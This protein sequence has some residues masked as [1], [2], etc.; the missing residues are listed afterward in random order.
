MVS[1]DSLLHCSREL[2]PI[3]C[4]TCFSIAFLACWP[5]VYDNTIPTTAILQTAAENDVRS[6][7]L[8]PVLNPAVLNPARYTFCCCAAGWGFEATVRPASPVTNW[9]F[10]HEKI[11]CWASGSTHTASPNRKVP[12]GCY[13]AA[14]PGLCGVRHLSRAARPRDLAPALIP[15][16]QA[17]PA[18]R[19]GTVSICLEKPAELHHRHNAIRKSQIWP[20]AAAVDAAFILQCTLCWEKKNY[21]VLDITSNYSCWAGPE[22][23]QQCI[24][25]ANWGVH[26]LQ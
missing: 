4:H 24:V 7:V 22:K 10:Q 23:C 17:L 20:S 2:F 25:S 13:T 16:G 18:V 14:F 19:Q 21:F 26:A 9:H 15:V 3:Y 12:T 1:E 8:C 6:V 5:G 11:L